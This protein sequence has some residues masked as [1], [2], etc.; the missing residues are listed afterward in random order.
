MWLM[1]SVERAIRC[2]L[3]MAVRNVDQGNMDPTEEGR[4]GQ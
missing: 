4:S 1:G 2:T 3:V